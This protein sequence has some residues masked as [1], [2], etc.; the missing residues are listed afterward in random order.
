MIPSNIIRK[1]S[2]WQKVDDQKFDELLYL[3]Q[4]KSKWQNLLD[5]ALELDTIK[6]DQRRAEDGPY[7]KR[8]NQWSV[9]IFV[10][11][12]YIFHSSLFTTCPGHLPCE[13]VTLV[14]VSKSAG[15]SSM[16]SYGQRSGE[17]FCFSC[18]KCSVVAY[19]RLFPLHAY[20]C[21]APIPSNRPSFID[22][23]EVARK[24]IPEE[25]FML[26]FWPIVSIKFWNHLIFLIIW[27]VMHTFRK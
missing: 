18:S 2:I 27:S 26:P 1:I 4:Q 3:V 7:F 10:S 20:K 15:F 5:Y 12:P 14:A 25:L 16:D 21:T 8:K 24:F 17:C 13:A 19:C 9:P 23:I 22:L 6:F 11:G